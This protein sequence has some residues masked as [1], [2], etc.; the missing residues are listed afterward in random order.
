MP[1]GLEAGAR[2]ECLMSASCVEAGRST[3]NCEYTVF[4][5]VFFKKNS[6]T[7]FVCFVWSLVEPRVVFRSALNVPRLANPCCAWMLAP[8]VRPLVTLKP[9]V[10]AVHL[11]VHFTSAYSTPLLPRHTNQISAYYQVRLSHVLYKYFKYFLNSFI[12]YFI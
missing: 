12:F 10:Q 11:I 6:R 5:K 9:N 7:T 3:F 8:R 4:S 2:W 1:W